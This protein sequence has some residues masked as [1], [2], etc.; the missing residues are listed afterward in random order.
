MPATQ[1]TGHGPPSV[2]KWGVRGGCQSWVYTTG[3]PAARAAAISS[4]TAGSTASAPATD[5]EPSGWAKSFC[6]STTT[7]AV[8]SS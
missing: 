7:S 8:A 6:T 4:F 5:S 2:T 3:A 1:C